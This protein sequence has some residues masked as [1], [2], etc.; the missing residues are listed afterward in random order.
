[1]SAAPVQAQSVTTL[2]S[3]FDQGRDSGTA[4][5]G[6]RLSRRPLSTARGAGSSSSLPPAA[7]GWAPRRVPNTW[8]SQHRDRGK[9]KQ[10]PGWDGRTARRMRRALKTHG[11]APHRRRDHVAASTTNCRPLRTLQ[12][13]PPSG[14]GRRR[15][16]CTP[17][18]CSARTSAGNP[19]RPRALPDRRNGWS[20]CNHG[21]YRQES[22]LVS[23]YPATNPRWPAGH[24]PSI[25][26]SYCL[27][28]LFQSRHAAALKTAAT[29][30]GWNATNP[31]TNGHHPAQIPPLWSLAASRGV[32]T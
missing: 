17:S 26:R 22:S 27:R 2:V 12:S 7:G 19:V 20:H 10:T 9:L 16:P 29:P 4:A 14:A 18:G 13:H 25:C 32:G 15:A 23:I 31:H 11:P 5:I 24:P 28:P 21:L 3:N 8:R 30:R 6:N 1:M